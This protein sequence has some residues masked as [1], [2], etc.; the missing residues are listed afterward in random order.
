[1]STRVHANISL[2]FQ[3]QAALAFNA[4]GT[5]RGTAKAVGITNPNS[6]TSPGPNLSDAM[7]MSGKSGVVSFCCDVASQAYT[8][9]EWSNMA[10]KASAGTNG[11]V[12]AGAN[13]TEYTKTVDAWAKAT[14]TI[15]ENTPFFIVAATT[16]ANVLLLGGCSQ[17]NAQPLPDIKTNL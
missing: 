17:H 9:Y 3:R 10:F 12:L 11:W 8:I 15:A 6:L 13:S 5:A 4:G 14:F 7:G 16:P 1:M 2:G